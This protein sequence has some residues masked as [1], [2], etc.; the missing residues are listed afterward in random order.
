MTGE[1]DDGT[2]NKGKETTYE[3]REPDNEQRATRR[4]KGD[5][6]R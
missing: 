2:K 4:R 1:G 3:T 5:E 6:T